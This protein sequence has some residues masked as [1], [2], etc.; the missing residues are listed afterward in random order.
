[1]EITAWAETTDR[2]CDMDQPLLAP[3]FLFRFAVPCRR[4]E[5][6]WPSD[7]FELPEVNRLPTFGGLEDR[8]TFADLRVGWN[9]SGLFFSLQVAGKRQP[10]WCRD[11]RIEDSDGLHVW[12]D[13]R[14]TK[15]IH[16]AS[17]FCHRFAFLPAGSGRDVKSPVAAMLSINRARENAKPFDGRRLG[18]ISRIESDGYWLGGHIPAAGLTG[19]D[20]AEQPRLGF[21]YLVQDR[22][23]GTQPF[24]I[25]SDFPVQEDPSLW[26]TLELQM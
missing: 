16:R 6:S 23:R 19:F 2:C 12:L 26:G 7:S 9:E 4:C 14:D 8:A 11:S 21:Y 20:P 17:R 3:T 24:A 5:L 22:E 10:A 25:G 15:N 18:V 13:T 1:M